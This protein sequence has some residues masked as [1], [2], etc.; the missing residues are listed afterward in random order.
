MSHEPSK[1]YGCSRV[2]N[3]TPAP[4]KLRRIAGNQ[5]KGHN[6]KL[7]SHLH[8]QIIDRHDIGCGTYDDVIKWKHFPR[9]WPFVWGIHRSRVN[10]PHKDQWRG[11]LMFSLIC[12]W[13]NGWVNSSEA[14]DLRRRRAHYDVIALH[15]VCMVQW[16]HAARLNFVNSGSVCNSLT[17]PSRYSKQRPLVNYTH[18]R[19]MPVEFYSLVTNSH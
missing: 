11:V 6:W 13:K 16:C 8:R 14:G 17:P 15:S 18:R 1:G 10:S 9:Y 7:P 3:T 2:M 5:Y 19:Q 12:T 4:P